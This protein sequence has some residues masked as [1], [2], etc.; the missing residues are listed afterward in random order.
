MT[1]IVIAL[2]AG[3]VGFVVGVLVY[4]KHVKEAGRII[5]QA[6]DANARLQKHLDERKK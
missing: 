4:R 3:A 6:Q 2:I 5:R 1:E